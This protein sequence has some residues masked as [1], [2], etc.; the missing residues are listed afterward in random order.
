MQE[1]ALTP[2]DAAPPGQPGARRDNGI[3]VAFAL[4]VGWL[5]VASPTFRTFDNVLSVGEQ[6]AILA[7]AAFAMTLVIV[8]GAIDL[9]V[10][11]V[12]S[13]AGVVTALRLAAG[14]PGWLAVAVGLLVAVGFGMLNAAVVVVGRVPSFIATL[15]TFYVAQGVSLSLTDGQTIAFD[16]AAFR[17][18]FATS[19]PAGVPV[20]LVWAVLVFAVLW[21]LLHRT[22]AGANLFA[23]GGDE[24][25]ARMLGVPV[26]RGRF[27]V[28]TLRRRADGAG[29]DDSRRTHRQRAQRRRDRTRVRRDR[30]GADR[31]HELRGRP[32]LPAAHRHRGAVHRC[33][34]Q[35][36]RAAQRRLQQ[37]ADRQGR[38]RDRGRAAGPLGPGRPQGSPRLLRST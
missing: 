30:R 27:L 19:S 1:P 10:G 38:A 22:R 7:I 3:L 34:E 5:T 29:R 24:R 25:S 37:P 14:D 26:D 31:R 16:A 20:A 21:L 23:A 9:S 28:L 35:R 11:A 18:T 32:R 6:S 15:A 4:L 33:P 12:A 8:C 36:A 13:A 2:A 17:S